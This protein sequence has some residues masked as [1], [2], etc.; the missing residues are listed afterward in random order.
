MA[1]GG[2][3]EGSTRFSTMVWSASRR[4]T[5][6]Q[7]TI[8]FVQ[9]YGFDGFDLDWEY[10][11]QRGGAATDKVNIWLTFRSRLVIDLFMNIAV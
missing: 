2:W 8:T 4:A 11:A 6:I 7:S 5:F 9:T 3:N 10:P 1:I